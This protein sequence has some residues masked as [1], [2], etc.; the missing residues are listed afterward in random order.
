MTIVP[1]IIIIILISQL[2]ATRLY[3]KTVDSNLHFLKVVGGSS[4]AYHENFE[5]AHSMKEFFERLFTDF[6][7]ESEEQTFHV[8]DG[9]GRN[10][11]STKDSKIDSNMLIEKIEKHSASSES[12]SELRLPNNNEDVLVSYYLDKEL[13]IYY[14]LLTPANYVLE[15]V[16]FIKELIIILVIVSFI[17]I[18]S[19]VLISFYLTRPIRRLSKEMKQKNISLSDEVMMKD[20][21]WEISIQLNK[22]FQELKD[23]IDKGYH[24]EIKTNKAQFLALQSQINPHFL[25]NT[26]GTINSIA[27]IE[28]VPLIAELTR[29][30]SNMFRYNTIQDKEYVFLKEELEHVKNYLRVQLIRFDGMIR[31]EIKFE[32]ELLECKTIKFMLQPI[33]ENC[34]E[35]AFEHLEAQGLIRIV[36]YRKGD[37]IIIDVEDNGLSWKQKQLD[38]MNALFNE[39]DTSL[40]NEQSKGIGLLN[41]NT[42]IKLA[43]GKVYG[44]SFHSVQPRGLCVKITLPFESQNGGEVHVSNDDNRR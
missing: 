40:N 21:V 18:F 44:L 41:V 33:V 13:N 29:S 27:I 17:S 32:D 34:F 36:G 9:E 5:T 14:I 31:K 3:D 15:K 43:F 2:G 30:L 37:S 24:L 16:F 42:R 1:I 4:V 19:I 25:Y 23:Q 26:L 7:L 11:F 22:V 12:K 28:R 38:E 20:E 35:H 8:I 6:K 10:V 39:A